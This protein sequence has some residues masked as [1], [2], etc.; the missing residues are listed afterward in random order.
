M[1]T[2]KIIAQFGYISTLLQAVAF[3][4]KYYRGIGILTLNELI[5]E[6]NVNMFIR[7]IRSKSSVEKQIQIMLDWAQHSAGTAVP[8][9]KDKQELLHLESSWIPH[10][11]KKLLKIKAHIKIIHTWKIEQQRNNDKHIM[12]IMINSPH[13]T[14]EQVRKIDY[15]WKFLKATTLSDIVTLDGKRIIP[16]IL[17]G[18]RECT[19]A[20]NIINELDWPQQP[21]P[22][23]WTREVWMV[24]Q[25]SL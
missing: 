24:S 1:I 8:L 7:H 25:P 12:D 6:E 22:S 11:W 2:S 21:K 10:L 14:S 5:L 19:M 9:L 4:P 3:G 18:E 13:I 23:W 16:D 15:Y 20:D 17:A